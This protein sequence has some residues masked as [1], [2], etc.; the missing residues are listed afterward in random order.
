M[1]LSRAAAGLWDGIFEIA[2]C[3]Y[4]IG[5]V[6]GFGGTATAKATAI[7]QSLRPSDFAPAF[8]REEG[9]LGD[10]LDVR[11]EARTSSE[12]KATAFTIQMT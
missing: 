5:A 7:D 6:K 10:A 1:G 9:F 11:A 4:Y 3:S 8:G 2:P 12:A